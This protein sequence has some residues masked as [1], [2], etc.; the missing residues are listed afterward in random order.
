MVTRPAHA[1]GQTRLGKP[2]PTPIVQGRTE[3]ITHAY[4]DIRASGLSDVRVT[5]CPYEPP[6]AKPAPTAPWPSWRLPPPDELASATPAPARQP[7]PRDE[8]GRLLPG[9]GTSEQARRAALASAESRKLKALLGLRE[10]VEGVRDYLA[11][12]AQWRD[13]YLKHLAENVGGGEV[14]PDAAM[15][16]SNAARMQAGSILLNDLAWCSEDASDKDILARLAQARGLADSAKQQMLAAFELTARAA[17][18]RPRNGLAD[19]DK[20]LG[21]TT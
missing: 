8:Q 10:P 11:L 17:K 9:P 18:S 1:K 7:A 3:A 19:L 4:L 5:I 6:T 16:A 14:P 15:L 12:V 21:I 13:Q 20:R 2:E